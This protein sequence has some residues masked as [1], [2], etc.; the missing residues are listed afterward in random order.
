MALWLANGGRL[1]RIVFSL[2]IWQILFSIDVWQL[3]LVVFEISSFWRNS[4]G[5]SMAVQAS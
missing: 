3:L 1:A 5:N 2:D 4:E